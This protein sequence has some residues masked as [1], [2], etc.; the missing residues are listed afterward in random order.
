[1]A[2]GL[3]V[4]FA[5]VRLER[6]IASRGGMPLIDIHLLRNSAFMRGLAAVFWFFFGNLSF[7]LVMTLFLQAALH[8][9]PLRT[10]LLFLPA[11]FAFVNAPRQ[12]GPRMRRRG[13]VVL[14]EGGAIQLAALALLV[15]SSTAVPSLPQW[16]LVI[17]LTIF[18][19]GQGYVMAPL[20]SAVL[21]SVD[22]KFA[23]A[24]A[25]MYATT[26]QS[27]NAAGVAAVG[28]AYFT[29]ST[30]AGPAS[31]PLLV[32]LAVIALAI[33]TFA[34]LLTWMLRAGPA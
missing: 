15:V 12:S 13:A 7:Y 28:A 29:A 34:A 20:S 4:I 18:G 32:S 25:G 9:S 16:L 22:P 14:I 17:P 1:M 33:L 19:Y 31:V 2:A 8:L 30:I 23:G 6:R 10:G 26:T 21:A 27:A 11:A 3:I 24:A 5:F